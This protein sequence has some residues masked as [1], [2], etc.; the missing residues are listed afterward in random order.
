M[1]LFI[2]FDGEMMFVLV[3]VCD[4]DCLIS[5]FMVMLFSI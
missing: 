1:W 3:L 4:I 2:M 5:V